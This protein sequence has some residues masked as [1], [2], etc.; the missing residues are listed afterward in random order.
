MNSTEHFVQC[1]DFKNSAEVAAADLTR[2]PAPV[3]HRDDL[4]EGDLL[5]ISKEKERAFFTMKVSRGV[6]CTVCTVCT[7]CDLRTQP[8]RELLASSRLL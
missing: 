2:L 7:V 1:A 5:R 3:G 6:I 4:T 8:G